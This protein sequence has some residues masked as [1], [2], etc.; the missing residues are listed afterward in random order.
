MAIYKEIAM[1]IKE[2]L[3]KDSYSLQDE[4]HILG[5][6]KGIE[7]KNSIVDTLADGVMGNKYYKNHR[8]DEIGARTRKLWQEILL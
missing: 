5:L 3:R 2:I 4:E 1:Q 8:N 6:L 7:R